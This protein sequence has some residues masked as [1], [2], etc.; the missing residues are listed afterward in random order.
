MYRGSGLMPAHNMHEGQRVSSFKVTRILN[1][2]EANGDAGKMHEE[3][4]E[5][6]EGVQEYLNYH[7]TFEGVENPTISVESYLMVPGKA[8]MQDYKRTTIT[9]SAAPVFEE[10]VVASDN[11]FAPVYE[12]EEYKVETH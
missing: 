5:L 3:F 6:P 4:I 8:S 10:V 1:I 2:D 9:L 11:Y 7:V 12:V